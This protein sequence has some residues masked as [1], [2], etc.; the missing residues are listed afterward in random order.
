VW[1]RYQRVS[2]F[3]RRSFERRVDTLGL[4]A[5]EGEWHLVC[6]AAAAQEGGDDRL[7]VYKVRELIE[8][9]PCG[10]T[11]VRPRGFDLPT[12]WRT[13]CA[14]AREAN[15][16]Y[17]VQ[18]RVSP[19]MLVELPLY[20]G[21]HWDGIVREEATPTASSGDDWLSVVL[22]FDTFEGA[23]TKLLGLGAGIEVVTPAALRRSLLDFAEQVIRRYSRH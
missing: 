13:W 17:L 22:H 18:A 15:G 2:S 1:I 11:F 7:R 23:R 5:K 8:V 21:E 19:Q 12:A 3:Y 9:R 16:H 6:T 10:E 4:V 20:L 14:Q